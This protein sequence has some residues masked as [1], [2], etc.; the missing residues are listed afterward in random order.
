M[1]HA[2]NKREALLRA[3]GEVVRE[4]GVDAMTLEAVAAHARVSKGGLLYHFATKDALVTAMVERLAA[5]FEAEMEG[6]MARERLEEPGA[7]EA[8]RWLRAYVRVST[9][10]DPEFDAL[11]A[12]LA[13][14][15]AADPA[16]LRPIREAEARWQEHAE[17]DGINPA[18]AAV[19]RLAADGCWMSLLFGFGIGDTSDGRLRGVRETLLGLIAG[20]AQDKGVE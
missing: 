1:I 18:L 4:R 12:A 19:V 6:E 14:A 11:A 3:A 20:A 9:A 2:D 15:F 17:N 10:P 8:G 5:G 16:L 7:P 13:A